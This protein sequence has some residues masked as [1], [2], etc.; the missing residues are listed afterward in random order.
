MNTPPPGALRNIPES[1]MAHIVLHQSS[2]D[3]LR[4]GDLKLSKKQTDNPQ[5][6]PTHAY[7]VNRLAK[8]QLLPKVQR[9]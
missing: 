3:K 8:S 6:R 7:S 4:Q 1:M 9:G 5:R 2:S